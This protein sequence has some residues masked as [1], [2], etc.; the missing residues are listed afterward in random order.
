[1]KYITRTLRY[2]TGVSCPMALT[3]SFC[4]SKA[5]SDSVI[6]DTS[7]VPLR[8]SITRLPKGGRMTGTACGMMTYRRRW[9]GVRFRATVA[10]DCPLGTDCTAP[11]TISA[12]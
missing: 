2:S 7:A 1:M 10:S 12:P 3:R 9:V 4:A 5:R 8:I 11:R 6:R